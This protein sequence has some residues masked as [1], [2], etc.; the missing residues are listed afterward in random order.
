MKTATLE[1]AVHSERQ[2]SEGRRS[3]RDLVCQNEEGVDGST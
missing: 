3:T 2:V 1:V